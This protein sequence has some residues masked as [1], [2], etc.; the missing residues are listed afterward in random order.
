MHTRT[1]GR[2]KFHGELRLKDLFEQFA[3]EY[4]RGRSNTKALALLKKSDLVSILPCEIEFVSHDD[5]GVTVCRSE[6]AERFQQINLS[7]DVEMQS[8]LI[9]E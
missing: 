5:D 3:L 4:A 2:P 7:S 1:A 6:A 8:R 9:E